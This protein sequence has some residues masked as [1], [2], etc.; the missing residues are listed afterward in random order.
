VTVRAFR[1]AAAVEFLSLLVLLVN[2]ATVHLPVVSSLGGPVHGCAYLFV[3]VATL[4]NPAATKAAKAMA[5]LPG[6][7]GLLVARQLTGLLR[8]S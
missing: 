6:I 1:V 8:N 3:V 2:L 7:G 4:R 5:W